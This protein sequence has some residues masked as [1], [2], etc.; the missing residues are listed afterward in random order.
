MSEQSCALLVFSDKILTSLSSKDVL[1][2]RTNVH[3]MRFTVSSFYVRKLFSQGVRLLILTNI[4]EK[5]TR[6]QKKH[7]KK[8][9]RTRV[10]LIVIL[11]SLRCGLP[12][13][14]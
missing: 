9:P 1:I 2:V 14:N 4:S 12:Q 5:K 13:R 8:K 6:K 10:A 7:K 3:N 11:C